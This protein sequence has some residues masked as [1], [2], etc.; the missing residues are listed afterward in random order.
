MVIN[1]GIKSCKIYASGHVF[2]VALHIAATSAV[3]VSLLIVRP[4]LLCKFV[5]SVCLQYVIHK[6][7]THSVP[8]VHLVGVCPAASVCRQ[9]RDLSSS[10]CGRRWP[11][12][13]RSMSR[14][15]HL[16]GPKI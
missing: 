6:L 14:S 12:A 2:Q 7:Y 5:F 15:S 10:A 4:A 13:R 3:A 9:P 11:A 8:T 1:V 16:V